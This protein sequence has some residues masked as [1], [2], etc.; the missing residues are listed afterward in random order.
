[1]A[2]DRLASYARLPRRYGDR[3]VLRS[4]VDAFGRAHWMLRGSR[5]PDDLYD[6]V[7]V[8]VEDGCAYET[9]LSSVRARFPLFDALPDGG[10]VVAD[11]RT[12]DDCDQVQVFDAL[13]RPSWTFTAGDAIEHLLA[14]E[15][16][17]LWL[18]YFDEGVCED[19]LSEPGVRCW[20]STGTP[21][22]EYSPPPGAEGVVACEALNVHRNAAWAYLYAQSPLLEVRDG[23][24]A[25]ARTA[26][27][28]DATA[29]AVHGSR[30]ALFGGHGIEHDRLI[31][32]RLTETSVEPVEECRLLRPDGIGLGG[33][34]G[35]FR[36]VTRGPRLYVQERPFTEWALLDIS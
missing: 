4:T 36:V 5:G 2:A 9:H 24:A 35:D 13:G 6:A 17:S 21:L 19:S 10:F 34:P 26:P 20:S 15:S 25:Q 14:D 22:W 30:V 27:V 1:M 16:G 7:V 32:G 18:G 12:R 3:P 31:L 8:T 29:V 23:R 28:T 33:S 11:A